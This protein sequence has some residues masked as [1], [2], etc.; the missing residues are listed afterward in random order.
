MINLSLRG[1]GYT[2][3]RYVFSFDPVW[4]M[5]ESSGRQQ[6]LYR[7]SRKKERGK[8][9]E[10]RVIRKHP[11][12]P[13]QFEVQAPDEN[14]VWI[15]PS[16]TPT[17]FLQTSHLCGFFSD[18]KTC[19]P[20]QNRSSPLFLSNPITPSFHQYSKSGLPQLII[21]VFQKGECSW[22]SPA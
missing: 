2:Y 17:F 7:L 20:S 11:E 14:S 3:E 22:N 13:A 19:K 5:R 9:A 18:R 6:R 8:R 15:S 4:F 10:V 21:S 12:I 1:L 16:F